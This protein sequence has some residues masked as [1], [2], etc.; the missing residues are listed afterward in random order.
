MLPGISDSLSELSGVTVVGS[1]A[2]S[3][4][5][6]FGPTAPTAEF[7]TAV[8]GNSNIGWTYL[9]RQVA[10]YS[11]ILSAIRT[12]PIRQ[13][14]SSINLSLLSLLK[15][16]SSYF[17]QFI[18][19]HNS[20]ESVLWDAVMQVCNSLEFPLE[21]ST[22][23]D[24]LLRSRLVDW[25]QDNK[26]ILRIEKNMFRDDY[27][28]PLPPFMPTDDIASTW[29][30]LKKSPLFG[31]CSVRQF[32]ALRYASA[33]FVV[34]EWKFFVNKVLFST[35]ARC[36]SKWSDMNNGIDAATLFA[37]LTADELAD[38]LIASSS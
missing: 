26:I 38:F 24:A 33:V 12:M 28:G 9:D 1:R 37:D 15:L 34:K 13:S 32:E 25:E 14:N 4:R 20:Y 31:N 11:T 36:V 6:W 27:A 30:A 29:F 16:L 10:M 5:L 19:F 35:F 18:L 21:T 2:Q 3:G 8:A 23:L 17:R 22:V 7:I